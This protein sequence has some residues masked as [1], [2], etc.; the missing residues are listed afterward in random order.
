MR[1]RRIAWALGIC[2]CSAATPPAVPDSPRTELT[3]WHSYRGDER[4]AFL[5]TVSAYDATRPDL[6]VVLVAV[7]HDALPDKLGV[8][9]PRGNGPDVFVFAHDRV[10]DWAQRSYLE[11]LGFL[12]DGALAERFYDETLSPL[13]YRGDLYG[14]PLAFKCLA[15]YY[16][17]TLVTEPARTT[18]A[19]IA[20]TTALR[21]RDPAVWGLGYEVDSLYFHQPFLDGFGG[22][23]Y[24][25]ERDTLAFDSNEAA[26]SLDFVRGLLVD[27][28]VIP[29]EATS[30]LVSSLF[31]KHSLAYV[32]SGP[33]FRAELA[34]HEGWGVAPL[35][36]VSATGRPSRPFLGV[37]GLM[38]N[39]Y[40]KHKTAAF[41]LMTALT[42]D[43]A[44]FVR[45]QTGGQLVAN[46]QVYLRSEVRDDPFAQV[47]RA[48]LGHSVAL[49]NRPHMR[50]M[51]TPLK[52]ALSRAIVHG[53][54]PAAA[55]R[56]ARTRVEEGAP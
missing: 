42:T 37:E 45:S 15:L 5:A 11:P 14:L 32:V 35:P 41:E 34:G 3:V 18:D 27:H 6:D 36:I 12:T 19:L 54:D 28:K 21:A 8:A 26:A 13:V 7:P 17:R 10:G 49:S 31:L 55:L 48:Q 50:R 16:D 52:D 20:Q 39:R 38:L 51:W 46:R 44:A 29:N 43:D 30:A 4:L 24:S 23:L 9:I 25:D 47:F 1:G 33:W 53:E 56:L 40:S 22:A 2:A